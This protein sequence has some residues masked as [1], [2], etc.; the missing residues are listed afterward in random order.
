MIPL[1]S[2]HL[3]PSDHSPSLNV[4]FVWNEVSAKII[5]QE[6]TSKLEGV[7]NTV[8]G[9]KEIKST[10]NKGA[11][12]ITIKFKKNIDLEMARFEIANLIRQMYTE[13]PEGV[14]YPLLSGSSINENTTPILTY[15]IHANESPYLIKKYTEN[16]IVTK[17]AT[18]KGVNK[19]SVSGADP[20]NWV[21]TYS[22]EK[23]NQ[24]GISVS[25]TEDAVNRFLKNQQLGRAA[26]TDQNIKENQNISVVIS[27]RA[28]RKNDINWNDI[29]IKKIGTR[30]IHLGDI[31][32][33]RL[34][35]APQ[36]SYFRINGKN[37]INMVVYAE[38][39]ANTIDVA[40]AVKTKLHSLRNEIRKDYN[41]KTMNDSSLYVIE[42]L[43]KIKEKIIFSLLILFLLTLLK[44]GSFK[45]ITV[46][47]LSLTVNILIAFIFYYLF[48]VELQ[49]YSFAGI[50]ISIGIII[51]NCIIMIEHRRTQGNN[52]IFLAILATTLT[53][54]GAL[55]STFLLEES[56]RANLRDFILAVAVNICVS[57]FVSLFFVPALSDKA[58]L[59]LKKKQYSRK[60]KERIIN[61]T[62]KYGK[63]ISFSRKPAMRW[64][65][66]MILVFSFGLPI[67]LL[68]Q[69]LDGNTPLSKTYNLTFGSEWFYKK[70]KPTLEKILGGTL[71]LFTENVYEKSHYSDPA[72]TA[73]TISASMAEGS[74]VEQLNNV[75]NK[76]ERYLSSFNEV[77]VF[78]TNIKSYKDGSITIYFNNESESKGFPSVLKKSIESK[79][80]TI[81]GVDWSVT[82]V[83]N[84]FSNAMVSNFK[85]N[86]IM[87]EGYNYDKLY[88]YAEVLKSQL[89]NGSSRIREVEISNGGSGNGNSSEY[90]LEFD[91]EKMAM[92]NIQ[93]TSVYDYLR[94]QT[95]SG[96]ITSFINNDQL[97]SVRLISDQYEKTTAWDLKN[98]PIYIEKNQQKLKQ[99][100]VIEKRKT[101]NS[102]SKSNQQYLLKVDYD[103]LGPEALAK[104]E[105]D[106]NISKLQNKLPLGFRV[107]KDG[108]DK[109]NFHNRN[110][111]YFI[112][113]VILLIFF[114]CSI[115]LE[116]FKQPLVIIM[117]IPISFIGVFLTFYL[118]GFNFDQG[119]YA[120]LIVLCGISVNASLYIINDFNNFRKASSADNFLKLYF[121]AFNHKIIPVLLTIVS[122]LSGLLPFLYNG[123]NEAFWFA[124]A[125]GTAGGLLFSLVGIFFFLPAFL[126]EK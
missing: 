99:T 60:S 94:N 61:L 74:T 8:K 120:S 115:L 118:F 80:L 84:G 113:V 85:N 22:S 83:G 10:T 59:S 110:Q 90:F 4:Q 75:I 24:Y 107:F 46:L 103:Y 117:I 13:L 23:L 112:A 14:S 114:I 34:K 93:P 87:L 42:Q 109:W 111:Y 106:R 40:G 39:G 16:K 20:F 53:T 108:N 116:S 36:Q 37:S 2:V 7:F 35:E 121:K 105:L 44:T 11:G 29:A 28:D 12:T 91:S 66:A 125:A 3:I 58:D 32:F 21:I 26:F 79:A 31:A 67:F 64:L 38:T 48:K 43:Q 47:F 1:L 15:S 119:G 54:S 70:T 101:A 30:I 86:R 104:K 123:Q 68:P 126:T 19:I 27:Y 45:Y 78:E 92:F 65:T 50:T 82:G 89:I 63:L 57:L 71:R 81:G 96:G 56:L 9:I 49:L 77:E 69:K 102:I 51:D 41:I 25:E 62:R 95:H 52:K 6:V 17:L 33:I 124:F 88:S 98:V 76:M 18:V 97:Q 100:A 73:L 72:R 5:E 55:F 122:T